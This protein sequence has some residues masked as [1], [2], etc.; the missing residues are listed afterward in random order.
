MQRVFDYEHRRARESCRLDIEPC[1]VS[2]FIDGAVH[3]RGMKP[4][5]RSGVEEGRS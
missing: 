5:A 3:M 4:L 2:Q 1:L